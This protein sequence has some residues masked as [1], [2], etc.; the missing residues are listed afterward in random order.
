MLSSFADAQRNADARARSSGK[1]EK[2]RQIGPAEQQF[3]PKNMTARYQPMDQGIISVLKTR[4]KTIMLR[5]LL[6]I[7]DDD[8][9]LAFLARGFGSRGSSSSAA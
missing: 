7:C 4:Y 8:A 9:A 1:G 5:R 3:L 2:K 6:A